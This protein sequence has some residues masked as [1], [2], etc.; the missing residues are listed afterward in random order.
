MVRV[1]LRVRVRLE[2]SKAQRRETNLVGGVAGRNGK[3]KTCAAL[4]CALWVRVRVRV[5]VRGKRAK[6]QKG[7]GQKG[8]RATRQDKTRHDKT[9][10]DKT[11]KNKTRQDTLLL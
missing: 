7:K 5:M 9:R 11:R 10:Q 8:K 2:A 6:G 1:R 3:V 4:T